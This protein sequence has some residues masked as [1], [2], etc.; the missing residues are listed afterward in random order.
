MDGVLERLPGADVVVESGPR[1]RLR[2]L[3]RRARAPV[4]W[5]HVVHVA[6]TPFGTW[7]PCRDWLAD[8][9]VATAAGGMA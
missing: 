3:S 4:D 1:R 6:V 7:G 8:D 9:L 2:T 5:R